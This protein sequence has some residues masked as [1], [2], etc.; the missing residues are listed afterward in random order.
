MSSLQ[1]FPDTYIRLNKPLAF[2]PDQADIT[3][4]DIKSVGTFECTAK[5]HPEVVATFSVVIQRDKT[6]TIKAAPASSGSTKTKK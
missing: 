4:P 6:L 5:L 3:V 1:S 2:L